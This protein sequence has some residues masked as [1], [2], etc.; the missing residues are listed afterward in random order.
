MRDN[1]QNYFENL[2]PRNDKKDLCFIS[3]P[4]TD[5]YF[6]GYDYIY[7]QFSF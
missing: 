5:Q 4:E 2:Q 7:D 3:L 1:C 6:N